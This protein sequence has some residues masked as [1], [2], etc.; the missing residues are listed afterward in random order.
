VSVWEVYAIRPTGGL[1]KAD[2]TR[3][4]ET[5]PKKQSK[6]KKL[7][8]KQSSLNTLSS[9]FLS[10]PS[11]RFSTNQRMLLFEINLTTGFN[12]FWGDKHFGSLLSSLS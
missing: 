1:V 4:F 2:A 3:T 6:E 8:D 11:T 12:I 7:N 9:F 10:S 5:R